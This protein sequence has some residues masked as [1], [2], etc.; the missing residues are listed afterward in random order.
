MTDIEAM[1][2]RND[3]YVFTAWDWHV[4]HC[5]LLWRRFHRKIA[6]GEEIDSYIGAVGH[7][8]HCTQVVLRTEVSGWGTR[9][10]VKY[11][12]F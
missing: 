5:A 7:S 4:A 6:A 1:L 2:E 11:P 3:M 8:E 10:F 12:R 9:V